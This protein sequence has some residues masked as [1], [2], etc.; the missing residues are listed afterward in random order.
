MEMARSMLKAKHLPNEYLAEAVATS[1]YILNRCPTKFVRNMVPQQAWTNRKHS[2]SH[3][4]VFGCVAYAHVPDEIRKKLD[5][6]GE[7]FIFI[8]YSDE[9]K[10]YKLYNLTR[11]KV[12]ININM[13]FV[14]DPIHY[15][16]AIRE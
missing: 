4:R 13:Q 10:A 5:N 3:F 15:E 6:K 12:I 1:V 7:K 2:V 8:G 9:S 16:E 11:K 14:E